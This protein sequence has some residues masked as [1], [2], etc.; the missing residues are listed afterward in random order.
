MIGITKASTKPS[1]ST[2]QAKLSPAQTRAIY[3]LKLDG[4]IPTTQK[5]QIV[6]NLLTI[7]ES[8]HGSS[9]EENSVFCQVDGRAK[10]AIENWLATQK[11]S[12]FK[13]LFVPVG[14]AYKDLSPQLL[15]PTLGKN[16]ILPQFRITYRIRIY[17]VQPHPF[18]Q[19][20]TSTRFGTS[21]MVH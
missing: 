11:G 10:M 9:D 8:H 19:H 2:R 12:T 16:T 21:S 17:L 18:V 20:K 15:Y 14:R 13:P 7:P 5:V 3:L 6:A 1:T 4:L